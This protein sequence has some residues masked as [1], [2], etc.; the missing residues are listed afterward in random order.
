MKKSRLPRKL[1]KRL[2]RGWWTPVPPPEWLKLD[3]Q[4]TPFRKTLSK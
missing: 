1:K 4:V 2:R 3:L